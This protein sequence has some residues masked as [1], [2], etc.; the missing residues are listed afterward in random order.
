MDPNLRELLSA[1]NAHCVRYVMVGG[2][3]VSIHAQPRMTKDLDIFI[4]SSRENAAATYRALASFGAPMADFQVNDF[5][6]GKSIVRFGVPPICIDILQQIDGVQFQ[7]VYANSQEIVVDGE[8]PVRCISDEDLIAN[9]MASGR[10]QDLADVSAIRQ[11]QQSVAW[12]NTHS[13]K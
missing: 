8:V 13:G 7:A 4:E 3:A 9:K 10:P 6:D 1:F 5:C 2:Y 12:R 11:R